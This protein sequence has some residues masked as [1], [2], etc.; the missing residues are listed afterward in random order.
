[1]VSACKEHAEQVVRWGRVLQEGPV[2]RQ[3]VVDSWSG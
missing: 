1:M 2:T 3:A